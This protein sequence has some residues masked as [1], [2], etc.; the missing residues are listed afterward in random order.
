MASSSLTSV[1]PFDRS[2]ADRVVALW[3]LLHPDWRWLDNP[4]VRANLF[5]TSDDVERIHYAVQRGDAVIATVFAVCMQRS[6]WTRNRHININ[7]Q[8][9]DV[10]QRLA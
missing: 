6:G 10:A 2:H 9:Q 5:G 4:A 1:V 7:A 8:P 3:R